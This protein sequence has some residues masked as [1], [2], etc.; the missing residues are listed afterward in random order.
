MWHFVLSNNLKKFQ[1]NNSDSF[2]DVSY[3]QILPKQSLTP[4]GF[5]FLKVKV[6]LKF[7]DLFPVVQTDILYYLANSVLVTALFW[8]NLVQSLLSIV[9]SQDIW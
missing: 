7:G 5:K 4:K 1:S 2:Q 9:L 8:E 6:M 3:H